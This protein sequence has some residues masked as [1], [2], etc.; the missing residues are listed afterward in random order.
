MPLEIA[1]VSCGPSKA[2]FKQLR[3][4]WPVSQ[5]DSFPAVDS[6]FSW[7][8]TGAGR[9]NNVGACFS[10]RRLKSNAIKD[11]EYFRG[12]MQTALVRYQIVFIVPGCL[13]QLLY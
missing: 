6:V 8:I 5:S 13:P 7:Q 2:A 11:S 4:V 3:L 10:K 12:I 9:G 1:S